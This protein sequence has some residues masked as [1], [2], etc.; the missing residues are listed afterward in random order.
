MNNDEM[1]RIEKDR[2]DLI[3]SIFIVGVTAACFVI[4]GIMTAAAVQIIL[5]VS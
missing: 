3:R 4:V 2:L 5:G 1:S